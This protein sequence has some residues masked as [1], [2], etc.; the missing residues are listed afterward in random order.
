MSTVLGRKL[1]GILLELREAK[2]LTQP[3]AAAALT[4]TQTK[5]VKIER[6]FSPVRDPDLHALCDLYGVERSDSVRQRLLALAQADR[7]RRRASGWWREYTELGDLVEY[8]QLE[9]AASSIRTFQNQLIPGL[10]Q[11]PQYARAIAVADDAWQ[12]PDEIEHFVQARLAR[13]ARLTDSRPLELWAVLSEAAL[14]QQVGGRDGMRE[15]LEHLLDATAMA[16]VK[17]QVLPFA[18]GAH[19]SMNGPFVIVGFDEP[20]ALDV[21]YLETASSTLW[22]E[23]DQDAHRHRGLF[24]GVRRS[25]LSPEASRVLLNDLIKEYR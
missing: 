8:I 2:G 21:V 12:D 4:A 20:A 23:R 1:G 3:Q 9:D 14:R 6:G 17:V 24:D 25:A 7:E 5:I 10:L 15:Q 18:A 22:L 11:T 13:Q 16:N 19:A